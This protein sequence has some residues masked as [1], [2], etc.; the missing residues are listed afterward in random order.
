MLTGPRSSRAP[1]AT[2]PRWSF[3]PAA[4]RATGVKVETRGAGTATVAFADLVTAGL[5]PEI[6]QTPDALRVYRFGQ[7]VPSALSGPPGGRPT[8]I[9]FVAEPFETDFTDRAPYV[10]LVRPLGAARATSRVH[11]LGPAAR[12]RLAA[13]GDERVLRALRRP[14]GRSVD[15][16]L[17]C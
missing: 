7:L 16:G 14:G 11:A 13:R 12:V 15:L 10:V 1:F 9:A 2:R 5:P 6:L 17:P 3:R 4:L 8:A